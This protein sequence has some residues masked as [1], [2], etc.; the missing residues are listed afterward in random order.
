MKIAVKDIPFEVKIRI[1]ELEKTLFNIKALKVGDKVKAKVLTSQGEEHLLDLKGFRIKARIKFKVNVGEELTLK[2]VEKGEN[3][4]FELVQEKEMNENVM[5]VMKE[6]SKTSKLTNELSKVFE[7]L[8]LILESNS[9]EKVSLDKIIKN[10]LTDPLSSDSKAQ[11]ENNIL[12]FLNSKQENSIMKIIKFLVSSLSKEKLPESIEA[13]INSVL[14]KIIKENPEEIKALLKEKGNFDLIKEKIG[15]DKSLTLKASESVK[16]ELNKFV[17]SVE[18]IKN[19]NLS[20]KEASSQNPSINITSFI[21]PIFSSVAS[22]VNFAKID[23][24]RERKGKSFKLDRVS[25]LLN[26][27]QLGRLI[28]NLKKVGKVLHLEFL[29]ESEEAKKILSEEI[30]SL[31]QAIIPYFESV[32]TKFSVSKGNEFEDFFEERFG[33]SE[34]AID[35]RV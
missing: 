21:I 24:K 5:K 18:L 4:K 10:I 9:N 27:S 16:E 3:I 31:K 30:E 13:K 7:N 32:L 17:K 2:V 35:I 33:A 34:S 6:V 25:L 8:K 15:E 28:I 19:H 29:T 12:E 14:E 26:M 22:K 20:L 11:I 1:S 23:Y